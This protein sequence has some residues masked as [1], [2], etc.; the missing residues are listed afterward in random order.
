MDWVRGRHFGL[1][2]TVT[3]ALQHGFHHGEDDAELM[4]VCVRELL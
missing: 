3:G 2:S 1:D 4:L